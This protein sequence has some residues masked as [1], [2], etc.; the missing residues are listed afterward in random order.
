MASVI[1]IEK[2]NSCFSFFEIIHKIM[3]NLSIGWDSWDSHIELASSGCS[4]S[5]F[6]P[7]I[8]FHVVNELIPKAVDTLTSYHSNLFKFSLFKQKAI[9]PSFC[10]CVLLLT[11]SQE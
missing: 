2:K 1:C 10:F 5:L 9:H 11:S 7:S 3:S 8:A 4:L 6:S